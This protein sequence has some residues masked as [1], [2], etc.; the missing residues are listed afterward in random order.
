M[1]DYLPNSVCPKTARKILYPVLG[2]AKD[3]NSNNIVSLICTL[4]GQL[5]I[6]LQP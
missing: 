6:A 1:E 5:R 3:P 4:I 2:I